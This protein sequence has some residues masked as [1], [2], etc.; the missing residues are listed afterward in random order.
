MKWIAK[1][2]EQADLEEKAGLKT[3]RGGQARRKR[4]GTEHLRVVADPLTQEAWCT[5]RSETGY[6]KLG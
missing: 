4:K 6:T 3:T 1:D 5:R 2:A